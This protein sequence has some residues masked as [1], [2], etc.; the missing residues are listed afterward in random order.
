[1][2]MFAGIKQNNRAVSFASRSFRVINDTTLNHICRS[3]NTVSLHLRNMKAEATNNTE[4]SVHP[5]SSSHVFDS[6][7]CP[8]C[9]ANAVRCDHCIRMRQA[10]SRIVAIHRTKIGNPGKKACVCSYR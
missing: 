9:T 8:E 2:K 10:N 4:F 6:T 5:T 7:G 3:H 1:M